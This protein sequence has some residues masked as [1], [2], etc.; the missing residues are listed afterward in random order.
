YKCTNR[1]H[2]IIAA[3]IR[4]EELSNN[5]DVRYL[6]A[7]KEYNKEYYY[8]LC[9]WMSEDDVEKF[10]KEIEDDDKVFVVVEDDHD[11]YFGEPPTKLENPKLFKPFEMFVQMYGLPAHNELD[12]TLFVGITYSLIFGMMFGGLGRGVLL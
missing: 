3:K 4:L 5:F 8:I 12:P 2:K 1:Q 10:L 7:R 11:A 9:G 6:A